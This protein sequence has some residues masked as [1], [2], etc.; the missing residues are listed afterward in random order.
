MK[1]IL[2]FLLIFLLLSFSAFGQEEPFLMIG[3]TDEDRVLWATDPP[4]EGTDV[5]ELQ[6]RLKELG[7]YKGEISGV[8]DY[9]TQKSVID[10]NIDHGISSNS[11]VTSETWEAL[12]QNIEA[13]AIK[14][15]T[16][17]RASKNNMKI[18]IDKNTNQLTVYVD[19]EIFKQY[20]VAIGKNKTPTPVGEFKVVNKSVRSGGALG[21][22]W[23]GLNVP[24]GTYGIHGT[25]K[26][27]S[28]GR[29]ASA[30]CIRMFN[31]HVQELFPMVEVG[32]PVIIIGDYPPLSKP[33]L[34][35]GTNSQNLIPIQYKLRELGIYWGPA[36][37]RFGAMT[38]S[39]VV[40]L[41]MLHGLEPTGEITEEIYSLLEE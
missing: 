38:A 16:N 13:P 27:W 2:T 24:W 31:E 33:N 40:Y 14:E 17:K 26:P 15:K 11:K 4:Q 19:D 23:M 1:N 8:Y 20:P 32:T 10:F 5:E 7:Y 6:E 41:Q 30:G 9:I 22:R 36:D 3:C 39:A 35:I 21:T 34:K 18:I 37:G 12:G 28:I 25:N 29:R